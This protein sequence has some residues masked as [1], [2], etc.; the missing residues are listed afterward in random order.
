MSLGL[1][2]AWLVFVVGTAGVAVVTWANPPGDVPDGAGG[3]TA[4]ACLGF[5]LFLLLATLTVAG[6]RNAVRRA[7]A[8]GVENIT[9]DGNPGRVPKSRRRTAGDTGGRLEL[10][11]RSAPAS[12]GMIRA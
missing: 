1:R 7:S 8:R 11:R 12:R 4:C 9:G 3:G 6:R 2:I 10:G 5:S